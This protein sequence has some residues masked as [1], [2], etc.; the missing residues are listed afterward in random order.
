MS[1]PAVALDLTYITVGSTKNDVL[2][3]QGQPESASSNLF[4][5]GTSHVYFEDE[6]VS[7]WDNRTPH[8]KVRLKPSVQSR[9]STYTIGSTKDTVLSVQGTPDSFSDNEFTYGTSAVHFEDGRVTSWFD[10]NPPLK[11]RMQPNK[12]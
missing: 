11:V 7:G 12:E 3:I 1:T 9:E 8:L 5:Y 10:H 2:R 4:T 6:K